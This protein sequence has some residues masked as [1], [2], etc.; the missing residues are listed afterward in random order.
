MFVHPPQTM[1]VSGD[2][3]RVLCEGTA[4]LDDFIQFHSPAEE[5]AFVNVSCSLDPQQLRESQRVF[6]RNLDQRKLL[7][8]VGLSNFTLNNNNK[9]D[10]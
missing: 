4:P 7:T 2:P 5:E 3:M 1:G 6:L 8:A 9:F 10:L